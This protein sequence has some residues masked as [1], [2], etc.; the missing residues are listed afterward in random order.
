MTYFCSTKNYDKWHDK[1][2][3]DKKIVT[4]DMTNFCSTKHYDK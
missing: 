2:L 4:H 1:L 3:F